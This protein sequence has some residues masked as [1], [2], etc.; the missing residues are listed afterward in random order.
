MD[1]ASA[2]SYFGPKDSTKL[3]FK[4]LIEYATQE[5][6]KQPLFYIGFTVLSLVAPLILAALFSKF[7]LSA[8]P[9]FFIMLLINPPLQLGTAAYLHH[10]HETNTQNFLFFF[11]PFRR[12]LVDIF[13]FS[14]LTIVALI[15]ITV[16]AV[17]MQTIME[18]NGVIDVGEA[19]PLSLTIVRLLTLVAILFYGVAM[20]FAPYYIYF[21]KLNAIKAMK[22][23]LAVIKS[24]WFWF[25]GLY[26]AIG[27][28]V[29]AGLLA[30]VVGIIATLP[31]ARIA[32]YYVFARYSGVDELINKQE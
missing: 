29:L 30:V 13:V 22:Q 24:S 3:S 11:R 32:S 26:I 14:I 2:L 5:F 19:A 23:S 16:P 4:K 25:L 10:K 9:A 8:T 31:I 15:V 1:L 6:L 18:Q 17:T 20:M 27:A 12:E 28:L 21:Y 7:G